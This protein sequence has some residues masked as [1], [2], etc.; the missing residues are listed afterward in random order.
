[1]SDN[2]E[3]EVLEDWEHVLMRPQ[4][5]VSSVNMSEQKV[6]IIRDGKIFMETRSISVGFYK[7]LNEILD[8]AVDEAKRMKGAM[9]SITVKIDSRTNQCEVTDTGGGFSRAS[10]INKKSGKTNV[11]TAMSQLKAGSNFKNESTES[12]IVGMNGMGAA[13]V[14]ILSDE[15]F[16]D[17]QNAEEHF[18]QEWQKFES[19]GPKVSK[20]VKRQTGTTVGFRPR[21]GVFRGCSWDRDMVLATMT[22]KRFLLKNDPMLRSMD[23]SVTF[24]D[25][26]LDLDQRFLPADSHVIKG[27]LGVLAFYQSFDGSGSVSFVNSAMC[28]G[29]HQKIVNEFVNQELDDPLGHHFY[30]T[31][32]VLNLAPRLVSFGDQNKTR[33]DSERKDIQGPIIDAFRQGMEAFFST[34]TFDA[35]RKK[36]ED[37]KMGAEVSKLR[38]AKKNNAGKIS[39]KYFP[40]SGQH[41]N[42]YVCEGLSA[43][44]GVNQ[45]RNPKTEGVFAL[46]GKI[47]N[48][49]SVSDLSSNEEIVQLMSVLDL[50]LDP[51]KRSYS[52]KRIIIAADA[53]QDGGHIASLITNFLC[54]WFPYVVDEGRLYRLQVP[55]VSVG[56]GKSIEYFY[57]MEEFRA[58]KNRGQVRY[59]KGLGSLSVEDWEHVMSDKRLVQ[60]KRDDHEE[61]TKFLK[62]AFDSDSAP[63]KSW[64]KGEEF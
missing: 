30:E 40:P 10:A 46:K 34:Q 37:R 9:P 48:V 18:R 53:D 13:L 14:N 11:E 15:F 23:F 17:T 20:G 58:S 63:R 6:P 43:A 52:Y 22:F 16:V 45:I 19:K 64:L 8:N 24:D 32:F 28:S 3:I 59:L 54:R 50:D 5:Y 62:M 47:K 39:T 12:S 44:G 51:S 36:V 49:R 41:E 4:V 56:S 60:I 1:M 26:L 33:L 38:K 42:I 57:S 29:I 2:K 61:S 35:I 21:K 55:L 27:R 31:F 25:E 7:L